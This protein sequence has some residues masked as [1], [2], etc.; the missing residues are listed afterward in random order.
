MDSDKFEVV[1]TRKKTNDIL[2]IPIGKYNINFHV[3]DN[4][5][6]PEKRSNDDVQDFLTSAM[7]NP[8]H[9]FLS[10][11]VQVHGILLTDLYGSKSQLIRKKDWDSINEN[12]IKLNVFSRMNCEGKHLFPTVFTSDMKK[13]RIIPLFLF[14]ILLYT[15]ND[16]IKLDIDPIDEIIKPVLNYIKIKNEVPKIKHKDNIYFRLYYQLFCNLE[17][18]VS[19]KAKTIE[20]MLDIIIKLNGNKLSSSQEKVKENN[21]QFKGLVVESESEDDSN[22]RIIANQLLKKKTIV[23]TVVKK[24]KAEENNKEQTK[25]I[26]PELVNALEEFV[27]RLTNKKID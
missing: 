23:Q 16:S 13:V 11:P 19:P 9:Y 18:L 26:K 14:P 20:E 27:N 25:K 5:P 4:I 24:R 2:H 21:N 7:N 22:E 3:W 17:R 6:S 10:R 12:F 1:I 8:L 15:L